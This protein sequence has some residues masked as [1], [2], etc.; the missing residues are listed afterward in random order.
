MNHNKIHGQQKKNIYIYI[1]IYKLRPSLHRSDESIYIRPKNGRLN[2]LSC[3]S[4]QKQIS[5]T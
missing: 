3:C 5:K 2:Q 4:F 1:Y